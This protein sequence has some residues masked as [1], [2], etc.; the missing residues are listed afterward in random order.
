MYCQLE[1]YLHKFLKNVHVPG[2]IMSMIL[3]DLRR[4]YIIGAFLNSNIYNL[5][6]Q[7]YAL[8]KFQPCMPTT[9]R[10]TALQSSKIICTVS[11]G[12]IIYRCLQ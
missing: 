5:L 1:L 9:F 10:V 4:P 12:K 8:A 7:V 3:F 11:N 2:N 6:S